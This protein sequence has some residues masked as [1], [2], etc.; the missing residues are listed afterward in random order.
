MLEAMMRG[1]IFLMM[2]GG[3]GSV[4]ADNS[5]VANPRYVIHGDSVYDKK[6]DLTWARCS[7]GQRWEEGGGCVGSV[8]VYTFDHAQK[9]AN[10]PW[11]VP[12]KEELMTLIDH[13]HADNPQRPMI[14]EV[15]FPN[16][17]EKR[18][19]Y[20]TSTSLG[21]SAGWLLRFIDGHG[22]GYLRG[23]AV[24]VRLVRSGQ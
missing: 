20:W 7:V 19:K 21:S 2:I 22:D 15:A 5:P 23:T 3:V 11:R 6:T 9:Q 8:N 24:A 4:F 13:N 14:D 18:L 12:T 1:W 10:G 17:D 16:M